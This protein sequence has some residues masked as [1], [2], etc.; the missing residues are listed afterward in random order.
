MESKL[1]LLINKISN[2]KSITNKCPLN[3]TFPIEKEIVIHLEAPNIASL[4]GKKGTFTLIFDKAIEV[5][6]DG[7]KYFAFFNYTN[8]MGMVTSNCDRTFTGV[9]HD[10][11]VNPKNWGCFRGQMPNSSE[12]NKRRAIQA[13]ERTT[14]TNDVALVRK[15]NEEQND[16]TAASYPQLE[17]KLLDQS[18]VNL[19]TSE[20]ASHRRARA[21][22]QVGSFETV[23]DLPDNFDWRNVSGVNYIP[24]AIEQGSCGSQ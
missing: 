17:G 10:V 13:P 21:V 22:Q 5:T 2:D 6:V 20:I 8:F 16:W 14:F 19:I 23:S 7:K 12:E 24:P 9:F 15:I 11:G 4:N 1:L 18:K 3:G